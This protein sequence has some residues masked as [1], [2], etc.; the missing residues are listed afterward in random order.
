MHSEGDFV[1]EVREWL[2]ENLLAEIESPETDLVSAGVLDSLAL[3]QLLLYLEE[4]FGL[5][6][7]M[8]QLEIEDLRSVRSIARL[9]AREKRACAAA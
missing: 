9:V 7:V 5:K 1:K 4:H 3:V 6:I 2:R 8:E